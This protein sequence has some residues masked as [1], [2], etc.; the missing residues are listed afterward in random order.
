MKDLEQVT[1]LCYAGLIK[2]NSDDGPVTDIVS[3]VVV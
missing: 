1:R 3:H 2:Y